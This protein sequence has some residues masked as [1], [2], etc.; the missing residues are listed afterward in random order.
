M[1]ISNF[2]LFHNPHY[3]LS[4]E[5]HPMLEKKTTSLLNLEYKSVNS[6]PM[7]KHTS[8]PTVSDPKQAPLTDGPSVMS[9]LSPALDNNTSYAPISTNL[10]Q[11]NGRTH[12]LK[13]TENEHLC[14][15]DHFDNVTDSHHD[16]ETDS[17][18]DSHINTP[19]C[20][21]ALIKRLFSATLY[22]CINVD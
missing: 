6:K 16:M 2:T 19:A 10:D 20:T 15:A 13:I 11:T 7:T 5:N 21:V 4:C 1:P 12:S 22:H 9:I 8:I 17:G 3:V 14:I 18:Y